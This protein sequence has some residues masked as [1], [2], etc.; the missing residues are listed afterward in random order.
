MTL[1]EYVSQERGLQ[2]QLAR[3]LKISPV[4]ISQWAGGSRRVPAE[5]CLP[6][7]EATNGAVTRYELRPDVFGKSPKAA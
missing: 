4:L 7:E 1:D 5:R 3:L 6:I 2:N